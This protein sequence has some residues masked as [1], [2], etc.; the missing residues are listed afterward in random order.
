[1]WSPQ[2]CLA[3]EPNLIAAAPIFVP[4]HSWHNI[5]IHWPTY[6][7]P[8]RLTGKTVATYHP[9]HHGMAPNEVVT[10][11]PVSP[12][13]FLPVFSSPHSPG[14]PCQLCSKRNGS[15]LFGPFYTT[16]GLARFH[17]RAGTAF[18]HPRKTR[19]KHSLPLNRVSHSYSLGSSKESASVGKPSG[20]GR[21]ETGR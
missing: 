5:F 14:G 7:K 13:P 1:M 21:L 2:S 6:R 15:R 10:V 12:S 4:S 16:Y 20:A 8:H 19:G 18:C 3:R 9:V 17:Q 11:L